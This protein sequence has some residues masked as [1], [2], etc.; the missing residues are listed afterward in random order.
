MRGEKGTKP[1][2]RGNAII[3]DVANVFCFGRLVLLEPWRANSMTAT[4]DKPDWLGA[5]FL[6]PLR[7]GRGWLLYLLALAV[8]MSAYFVLGSE[9]IRQTN[10]DVTTSDQLANIA[11]ARQ[12]VGDWFPHRSTYIQPLWPWVSTV[13]LE[14]DDNAYFLRGRWFNLALGA[15]VTALI[16]VLGAAFV[17]P[18][19]GYTMGLLAGFAVFLQRAH[20]FHPEPLLYVFFAVCALLMVLS[21]RANLWC[22]YAGWGAGFGLAY[23]ATASVSPLVA[24]YVGATIVLLL[25][26]RGLLPRWLVSEDGTKTWSLTRHAFGTVGALVLAAALITPNAIFKFRVHGDPFFSPTKYWMW[27]DDWDTE[28]YPLY[29]RI[30]SSSSRAAFPPGELPTMRNYLR[31]HGAT[32][33]LQRLGEGMFYMGERFLLPARK[34]V[35][36]VFVLTQNGSEERGEPDRIWRFVMPARGLYLAVFAAVAAFLLFERRR[37]EGPPLFHSPPGLASCAF[38]VAMLLV[39]WLAFGWYAV[40]G[41]GERFGLMLYVPVLIATMTAGWLLARSGPRFPRMVFAGG[42]CVVL[43]H[44]IIQILRLLILPQFSKALS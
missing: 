5:L 6:R 35:P 32:H 43:A 36:A 16:F 4:Q 42:I 20:Y 9:L 37:R 34:T 12:S 8:A 23:L 22:F 29:E 38:V 7:G 1:V 10:L 25:A 13:V 26:R 11:L 18:V 27:C 39:Y 33:A 2:R 41:K 3:A 14:E 19:P 17:A 30:W 40:I 44:A 21:L 28:A 24:V 31:K 15:G